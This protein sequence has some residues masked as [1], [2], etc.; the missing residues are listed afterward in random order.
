MMM[1]WNAYRDQVNVAVKEVAAANPDIVSAD[2]GLHHANAKSTRI[3]PKTRELIALGVAITLR[4]DGCINVAQN[5]PIRAGATKEEIVHALGVA[6]IVDPVDPGV[7]MVH[8]A[9]TI[10]TFDAQTRGPHQPASSTFLGDGR[11]GDRS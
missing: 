8:S 4:S 9:P 6:I 10:D 7:A 2:T 5:A 11:E 1:D 3:A